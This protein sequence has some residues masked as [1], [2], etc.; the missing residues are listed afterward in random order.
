MNSECT[1]VAQLLTKLAPSTLAQWVGAIATSA[2]VAVALFKD[3]LLRRYRRPRL[4]VRLKPEPP[5]CLL[6]PSAVVFDNRGTILWSGRIY[7]LRLWI[8]NVGI[9]RAEQVQVFASRLFKRGA[10]DRFAP[11]AEYEPMNLR[12]ANT[13]DPNN[14]EIFAPG[15]SRRFGKHCDLCSISDPANPTDHQDY[16]G[17]CVGTLQLE[18]VPGGDRNRLPPGDYVVEIRVGAANA[19]P[20]TVHVQINIK[21][22]W[23]PNLESMLRDHLGV[24]ILSTLPPGVT[25]D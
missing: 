4:S 7:W 6:V 20:V 25:V 5:D 1:E 19:D 17:Q 13:R 16:V 22:P 15:I 2:A 18:V 12:W 10:N 23:S 3:E 14:P 21:G 11:V 8:A 24:Q 9:G